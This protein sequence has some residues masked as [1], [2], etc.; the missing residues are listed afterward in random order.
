[1]SENTQGIAE[2][3]WIWCAILIG[4]FRVFRAIT[5]QPIKP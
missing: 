5:V 1:V 4:V 2:F 3:F